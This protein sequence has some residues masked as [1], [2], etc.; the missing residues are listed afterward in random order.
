MTIRSIVS[1]TA[2]TLAFLAAISLAAPAWAAAPLPSQGSSVEPSEPEAAEIVQEPELSKP[3]FK[4]FIER[5]ILDELRQLRITQHQLKVELTERVV[6]A[7]L[8]VADRAIRYT[9]DTTNNIF[10]II[11][12][13][14]TILVL[15]GWKSVRDMRA[16]I[17]DI[18]TQK[19]ALLV[20]EYEERLSQIESKM[21]RRSN[22]IL[23]NQEEIAIT[24]NIHS[25]WMRAGLEKS[26]QEKI[27]IYD[28]ILELRPDDV[29]VLTYKADALLEIG[30]KKWAL[31]LADQA[32]EKDKEYSFAYW[33]RACAK[34]EIGQIEDAIDDIEIA[35]RLADALQEEI[36]EEKSF[37]NLQGNQRFSRLLKANS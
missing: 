17:E 18:T 6:E 26:E 11:T 32:I 29:E 1:S 31:S 19:M 35:V 2:V 27:N 36:A 34:A 20:E 4:P 33:Q 24:N 14:A 10:Y 9:A 22:Q 13:A 7:Q 3:L 15:L 37:V 12:A 28:Q 16:N 25:L 23:A 5:Y 30:E 21:R 8:Q